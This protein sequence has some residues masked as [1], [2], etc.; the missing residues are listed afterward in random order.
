MHDPTQ[1]IAAP[2]V[3]GP[4]GHE[5]HVGDTAI[6]IP[7]PAGSD[8]FVEHYLDIDTPVRVARIDV[9]RPGDPGELVLECVEL[10]EHGND[11]MLPGGVEPYAQWVTTADVRADI[12]RPAAQ[13]VQP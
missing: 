8:T 7:R 11:V 5:W 10:D 9:E 2:S 6:V 12:H 3:V 13:A 1:P 4:D